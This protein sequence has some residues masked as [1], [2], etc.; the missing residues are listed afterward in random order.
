M[1]GGCSLFYKLRKADLSFSIRPAVFSAGG[2]AE[3]KPIVHLPHGMKFS[4][5][6]APSAAH[7]KYTIS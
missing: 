4:G 5:A 1:A 7:P 2:N 3:L 6:G